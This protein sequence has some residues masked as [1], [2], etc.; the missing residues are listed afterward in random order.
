MIQFLLLA[1]ALLFLISLLLRTLPPSGSVIPQTAQR[2]VTWYSGK[3]WTLWILLASM[4]LIAL[5]LGGM[6]LLSSWQERAD[7]CSPRSTS[8]LMVGLTEI[9]FIILGIV[10]LHVLMN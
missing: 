2:V 1:P 10:G 6:A 3:L 9:A 5:V 7:R 8:A 4:P